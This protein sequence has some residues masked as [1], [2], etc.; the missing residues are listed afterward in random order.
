MSLIDLYTQIYSDSDLVTKKVKQKIREIVRAYRHSWDIYSELIQNSVD[1]I[2]RRY[3]IYYDPEFSLYDCYRQNSTLIDITTNYSGKI[4]LIINIPE[5]TIKI[6]D[7]GV[8]IPKDKIQ[9]FLLPDGTDKVVNQEYGFKG[10][11]L[12]YAA[13]I[14][15]S[16]YAASKPFTENNWY[17]YSLDGLFEWLIDEQNECEFPTGPIE[18]PRIID[19][20]V[21]REGWNT[22][23]KIQLANN[24]KELFPAVSAIDQA[25][26]LVN[27][28]EQIDGFEYILRTRTA[29]G[30]TKSLFNR[31]PL[32]P[33][34][35]NLEIVFED[36]ETTDR[37][38]PYSYYHP[39]DHVELS[40]RSFTFEEY[41]GELIR[42]NPDLKFR[43]LFHK[44]VEVIV[45]TRLSFTSN[46]A[47]AAISSTR[48]SRIEGALGLDRYET[49]DVG[50]SYGV[51]LAI[52]GMPTGLRIDDWDTKGGYLKRYFVVIDI[53]LE[54]SNQLDP[55]RKGISD[56]Y[57]RLFSD[58]AI[59]LINNTTIGD[60]LSFGTYAS[61][62]LDHGRGREEGGLPPQD[63]QN[64]I[65]Q[66]IQT[67]DEVIDTDEHILQTLRNVSSFLYLPN[68]EQE[69]IALFYELLSKGY[70]KG[71]KT[72]Y[73]SGSSA[74]YDAAL[75]YE[76][77]ASSENSYPSDIL[78]IGRVLIEH[79]QSRGEEVYVHA[80][81]HTGQT[82]YPELCVDF[83][84]HVGNFLN[85]VINSSGNTSK[86]PKAIDILVVWDT[87]IPSSIPNNAYTLAE[88]TPD[89]RIFHSTTKRLGLIRE[90]NTEILCIVLKDVISS[91]N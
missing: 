64:E 7:N 41:L 14:T 19:N 83:K 60:S 67:G 42:A 2:N 52:D 26:S 25:L 74:V 22:E 48:L 3:R 61:R 32:V 63:F 82:N 13:F 88:V 9:E 45:G 56:Y 29:I 80:N 10:Y 57:A 71:Y 46:F 1:A 11:G 16:F 86:D 90:Y 6:L 54:I 12:T 79:L 15:Q 53:D 51:Y 27:T 69:T 65:L 33:I 85:E 70:I 5:Q 28:S 50:I 30:N 43:S 24:Y 4:K 78:G 40:V 39:K 38:I 73:L 87:Y 77:I 84:L 23:I 17:E 49:K 55:G 37:V 18:E 68:D 72:L 20:D 81:H 35:V 8:G 47:L 36:G 21:A 34:H 91:I 76:I 31:P 59:N 75:K 44:I 62:H 89:Q 58:K 66:R